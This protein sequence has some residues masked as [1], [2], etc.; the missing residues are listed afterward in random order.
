MQQLLISSRYEA[1]R[2]FVGQLPDAFDRIG[3]LIYDGRN[4]VRRCEVCG[5]VVIVKRYKRPNFV[6]QLGYS[7]CRQNKA[8]RAYRYAERLLAM[9]VM[10]PSP[11]AALAVWHMGLV[12]E[13]YF[14]STEDARP[15]CKTLYQSELD[16]RE[17]L[18]DALGAYLV[19]LHEKGFLHG[20]TNLSNFLYDRDE[21][22]TYRFAVIDINRSEFTASMPDRRAC[23]QNLYRLTHRRE[24]LAPIVAAY[25]R[26]RGWEEQ[27]CVDEVMAL[28]DAFE[29]KKRRLKALKGKRN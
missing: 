20:D 27:S 29:E 28:L 11:I 18:V 8:V 22:G 16:D 3:T 7:T 15:S 23:L 19:Q 1:L 17:G 25:A 14:V 2:T 9:G 21:D 5:Q 6:Q 26:H 4:Q 10:T 24:V 12:R 13:Y